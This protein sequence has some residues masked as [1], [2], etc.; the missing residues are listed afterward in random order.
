MRRTILFRA[1]H[2]CT[3]IVAVMIFSG[4]VSAQG[5]TLE[6]LKAKVEKQYEKI[7][8]LFKNGP[9]HQLYPL[10]PRERLRRWQGDLDDAFAAAE[11]TIGQIL[12]FHPSDQDYWLE[13]R[14][15]M[16]LYSTPVSPPETR[17]VFGKTELEKTARLLDAPAAKY[18]DSAL[19]AK[20]KGEVRLRLVLAGDGTVKYIFPMKPLQHGLTEAAMEAAKQ[21]KFEPGIRHGKPASQFYTLSYEFKNGKGK[22]PYVPEHE[23]Y[24]D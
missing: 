14:E 15:T 9:A 20:A 4:S 17:E 8:D 23:F 21:I 2:I 1:G 5:P 10:N 13:R 11:V 6:Q 24:I 7:Y 19:A 12:R 16:R 3:A 22:P 18:P